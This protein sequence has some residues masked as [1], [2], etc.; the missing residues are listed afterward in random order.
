VS[1][2]FHDIQLVHA[3]K[4]DDRFDRTA[5]TAGGR[6]RIMFAAALVTVVLGVVVWLFGSTPDEV[7]R[8][9]HIASLPS[10]D[11]TLLVVE[12][13]RLVL[14]AF[15]S[16][17]N[18]SEIEF[19]VRAGDRSHFDLA[20]LRSHS[21]IALPTRLYYEKVGSTYFAVYKEDA[22]ANS[23]RSAEP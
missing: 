7:V 15:Q 1:D 12:P 2:R 4:G 8:P 22:P 20:H 19:T 3:P 17:D 18:E 23:T 13:D 11:G 16:L 5:A 14:D 9:A 6:R 21:S 10:V